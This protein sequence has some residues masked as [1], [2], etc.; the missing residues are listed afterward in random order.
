MLLLPDQL[1]RARNARSP[2]KYQAPLAQL[3]RATASGAVGQRFES[4]VARPSLRR[5]GSADQGA[6]NRAVTATLPTPGV[7]CTPESPNQRNAPTP[8]AARPKA[9]LTVDASAL[10]PAWLLRSAA[11]VHGLIVHVAFGFS[12]HL[13]YEL[14]QQVNDVPSPYREVIDDRGYGFHHF[15]YATPAFDEAVAGM[16]VAGFENVGSLEIPDLRLA[17]FDTRD[18]LPGMVEL[19]EAN[20]SVNA[21]FTAMWKA[22]IGER[23]EPAPAPTAPPSVWPS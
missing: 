15:G 10:N 11:T 19:I 5:A 8:S 20:E 18:V 12:G 1:A 16:N 22:S 13:V 2:K 17:Y 3:D 6:Q 23:G 4:S 14:I 9:K 7:T 21:T